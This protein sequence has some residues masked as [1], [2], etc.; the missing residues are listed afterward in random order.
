MA[1]ARGFDEVFLRLSSIFLR[2]IETFSA[3][4]ILSAVAK[5]MT[6]LTDIDVIIPGAVIT[7]EAIACAAAAYAGFVVLPT[8]CGGEIFFKSIRFFDF[9]FAGLF[10]FC[11]VLFSG[12][13]TDTCAAFGKKYFGADTYDPVYYD[14]HLMRAVFAFCIISM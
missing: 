14:C 3:L 2:A 5:F 10:I 4:F 13:M 1:F 8:F 6:D 7:I 11:A 12:D 9:V